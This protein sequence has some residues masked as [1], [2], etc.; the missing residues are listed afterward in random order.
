MYAY[1]YVRDV[2]ISTKSVL[3]RM[4]MW[5]D[6]LNMALGAQSGGHCPAECASTSRRSGIQ[7]ELT[8]G[9]SVRLPP[10]IPE[11]CCAR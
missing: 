11:L 2:A 4:V 8:G 10:L 3:M 5:R 9:E 6:A 7:P 1:A